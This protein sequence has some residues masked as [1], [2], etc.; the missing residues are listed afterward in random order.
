MAAAAAEQKIH[1]TDIDSITGW[2]WFFIFVFATGGWAIVFLDSLAEWF[3]D[4]KSSN[5][6]KQLLKTR[7]NN[8]IK[9]Y[10]ASLVAGVS[11]YFIALGMPTWIGLPHSVPE[12]II[13]I[14]VTVSAMGGLKFINFIRRKFY[15]DT[16]ETKDTRPKDVG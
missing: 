10:C 7:L 3:P 1:N 16:G 8:V 4:S 13:L 15:D 12:M 11:F 2:T 9:P 6:F 5:D 14:G